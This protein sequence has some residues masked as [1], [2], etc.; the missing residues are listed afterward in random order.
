MAKAQY[1]VGRENGPGPLALFLAAV[2]VFS[3]ATAAPGRGEDIPLEEAEIF[4]ELNH[5]DGDLGIHG[6][7]DGEAWRKLDIKSPNGRKILTVRAK[8]RLRRH[9]LTEVF[10][11]SEEPSF[12]ELPPEEFL[13]RFPEGEYKFVGRTVEGDK[14]E[15]TATLTHLLPAP[16]A[17]ILISGE[18]AAENCD[19]E[20]LPVVSD[21]VIIEWAPVT[22]SH[23]D[24]GTPTS[25]PAIEIV[26]YQVVV[27]REEPTL[28]VFSVDLPPGA[29]SVEVPP[30][31]IATGTEFKLEILVREASGNQTAVETCFEMEE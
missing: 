12:D 21:P 19:A 5:T 14:L 22:L 13:E 15:G 16:P 25:S 11:E 2:V 9:G 28:L 24:I 31:F 3:L 4:L 10:F 7:V 1:P 29:T 26:G 17:N 27:E 30:E 8:G 23:P 20:V 18:A 6:L